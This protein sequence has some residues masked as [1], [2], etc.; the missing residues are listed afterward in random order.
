MYSVFTAN[1]TEE[2]IVG[3][4]TASP[5]GV[6][7]HYQSSC[8]A[9]LCTIFNEKSPFPSTYFSVGWRIFPPRQQNLLE[10]AFG[11]QSANAP[12]GADLRRSAQICPE[13]H[14][15]AQI[16]PD[17][18]SLEKSCADHSRSAL[19]PPSCAEF[20]Q[21]RPESTLIC[22]EYP[23]W[24]RSAQNKPDGSWLPGAQIDPARPRPAKEKKEKQQE[25]ERRRRR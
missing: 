17:M 14:T 4:H 13:R 8:A 19:M 24:P 12:H 23:D 10:I 16:E 25:E 18:P 1:I 6:E 11:V 9:T 21:I 22:Q 20:V 15:T 3:G 2:A 7:R 5:R